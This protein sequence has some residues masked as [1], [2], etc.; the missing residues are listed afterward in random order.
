M[1]S[2]DELK[3]RI[4]SLEARISNA[5]QDGRN[6]LYIT[7]KFNTLFGF[8]NDLRD[9]LTLLKKEVVELAKQRIKNVEINELN[10]KK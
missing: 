3:K 4:E 7:G 10:L 2:I 8:T 9:S 1:A 6:P 5:E